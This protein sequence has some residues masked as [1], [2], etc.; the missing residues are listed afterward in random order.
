MD[1]P[2]LVRFATILTVLVFL[3]CASARAEKP[4]DSKEVFY[5]G[6]RYDDALPLNAK[7][8]Q[9][10]LRRLIFDL[11]EF[12][13][14][15]RG[16]CYQVHL[17]SNAWEGKRWHRCRFPAGASSRDVD[18]AGF[19]FLA[20]NLDRVV[21][22]Q[23]GGMEKE[24][25]VRELQ[26]KLLVDGKEVSCQCVEAVVDL[27]ISRKTT[28]LRVYCGPYERR[29]EWQQETSAKLTLRL[30]PEANWYYVKLN[31]GELEAGSGWREVPHNQTDGHSEVK[32]P[33]PGRKE[34]FLIQW[35]KRI[36]KGPGGG[37]SETQISPVPLPLP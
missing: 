3:P 12:D 16:W 30:S 29:F 25:V 9:P 23:R 14:T 37:L 7:V 36:Q 24:P 2:Q 11:S 18:P 35:Q 19:R 17:E 31:Y 1:A 21:V 22:I 33:W 26:H 8:A 4:D 34:S 10:G 27:P 28:H 32:A 13:Q 6:Q 20:V 15:G 5:P